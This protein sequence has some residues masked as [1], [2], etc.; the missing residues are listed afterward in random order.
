MKIAL[1]GCRSSSIVKDTRT[2]S[3][4][5]SVASQ[6]ILCDLEIRVNMTHPYRS[7]AL[8]T[9]NELWALVLNNYEYCIDC[10][11]TNSNLAAACCVNCCIRFA[12]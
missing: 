9:R 2:G 3:R 8:S 1:E 4:H 11:S 10:N 12:L 6:S 7:R 5:N